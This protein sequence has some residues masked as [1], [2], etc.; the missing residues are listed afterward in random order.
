MKKILIQLLISLGTASVS[1][2]QQDTVPKISVDSTI[3]IALANVSVDRALSLITIPSR[4]PITFQVISLNELKTKSIGQEPS[5]IFAGTPSITNYSDGGNSQG[6]SYF[7]LRG[8]DQTRINMTLD[9]VPL[10]E[11]E[12]QGAYFSNYPDIF[13]SLSRVVIHRGIGT[14][15]NGVAS[16]AGSISLFSPD[17][18]DSLK[19]TFGLGYGSF[20]S[21]RI[22][23]EFNSGVKNHKALYIRASQVYSDGYKVHAAN[24]SQSVFLSTGLFYL[25]N[26]LKLN[27]L[28]GQQRNQLAWLGVSDSLLSISRRTNINENEKDHFVQTFVQL[29][30][31]Y[32]NGRSSFQSSVYYTFLNGNYDFNLNSFLG[33]SGTNE[34][35]NYAFLS[36]LLGAYCN[37]TYNKRGFIWTTGV[38][39]NTY[40]RRHIGSEQT[41]GRLYQNRGFKIEISAYTKVQHT[42]NKWTLFGDIQF[43]HVDFDY[44]GSVAFPK[45]NWNFFNP[46]VGISY[47]I[48]K[49]SQIYYSI[50][51]TGREPTRND[52]FGGNDDLLMDSLGNAMIYNQTPEYVVDQEL[53]YRLLRKKLVIEANLYYMDFK[54]EIVLDG[55]LGPNGLAL[56]NKVDRSYRTG[57][58]TTIHFQ[59]HKNFASITNASYNY[60]RIKE[61]TISFTP[62]LT[63][64]VIFNQE[65]TYQRKSI[66]VSISGRYQGGAFIDFANTAQIQGYFILNAWLGYKI[67]GFDFGLFLNNFTNAKYYS[68]GY[69]DYDGTRKYFVQAPVNL[70]G[71]I[72]YSF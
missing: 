12:D 64:S 4:L 60:S 54:N 59:F 18:K 20:N 24:N 26:E 42:F 35:Y 5:F 22:F 40:Q 15:K 71:S 70:Y 3:L 50:G 44:S 33:L 41:L 55:K 31:K 10:N 61:Q 27:V 57:L 63:P 56:T 8:I 7:R 46:K 48:T 25:K 19:T 21:Y 16:Y 13:N 1:S 34:L 9:G 62:I 14:S 58:E 37:Y 53:G 36:N 52:L 47:H 2:A 72:K 6:Y 29:H 11:P 30:H 45:L 32:E 28:V 23:G 17:L 66:S 39:A 65:F 38:H 68:N 67:K 49:F 69:V 51:R 43:R